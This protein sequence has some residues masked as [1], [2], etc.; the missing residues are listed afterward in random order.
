M[1]SDDGIFFPFKVFYQSF[2]DNVFI[3][4]LTDR[5]TYGPLELHDTVAVLLLS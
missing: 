5:M 4:R 3:E 1:A 2:G